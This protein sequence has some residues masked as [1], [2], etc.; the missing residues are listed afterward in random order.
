MIPARSTYCNRSQS[1]GHFSGVPIFRQGRPIGVIGCGRRE[2]KPFTATQI[3]LLKTF[4]DQAAIAIE[5]VRLFNALET[6][7]R[8]LGEALEQQ[9]ATAEVLQVINRSPGDLT[10]VFD[11]TLDKALRLCEAAFGILSTYKGDDLHQVVAMRG[12]PAAISE[13]L[14]QPVHLGPETGMGRLARGERFVHI[15]DAADDD[16]YRLG[17]LV[18]RALVDVGGTRT[19]P[20]GAAAQRRFNAGRL[21]DLPSGGAS[22]H[23]QADCTP[24]KFRRAGGHRDGEC[25]ADHRDP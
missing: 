22:I 13:L 17:N 10:P 3:E 1:F 9:T 15:A 25:K 18:R 6:R 23:R 19:Y 7:N 4:T 11:A 12:V 21:H 8:D 16:G 2:V 24:R 5:N 20:G 14:R